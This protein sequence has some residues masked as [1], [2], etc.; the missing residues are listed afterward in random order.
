VVA[1]EGGQPTRRYVSPQQAQLLRQ[2]ITDYRA[3]QTLLREWEE[4]SERI[5]DAVQPRQP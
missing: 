5:I 2:A 4:N 3:L 1:H